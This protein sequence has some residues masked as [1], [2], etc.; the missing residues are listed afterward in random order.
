MDIKEGFKSIT[1]VD[2]A[3]RAVAAGVIG[4]AFVLFTDVS[5]ASASL[6]MGTAFLLACGTL[7]I[8][9]ALKL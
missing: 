8:G 2:L 6:F 1:V 3:T 7:A 9:R 4:T 5:V